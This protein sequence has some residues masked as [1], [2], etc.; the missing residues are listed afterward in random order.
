MGMTFG[1]HGF[2]VT[3]HT[4]LDKTPFIETEC[5]HIRINTRRTFEQAQLLCFMLDLGT[6]SLCFVT[7]FK[8]VSNDFAER[9]SCTRLYSLT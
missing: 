4:T 8:L 3:L 2:K 5:Q 1:Q 6:G 9:T 7:N